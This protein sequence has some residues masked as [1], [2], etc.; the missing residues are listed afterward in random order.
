MIINDKDL[1]IVFANDSCK[2]MLLRNN[3]IG[4]RNGKLSFEQ[5]SMRNAVCRKL[6]SVLESGQGQSAITLLVPG[7]AHVITVIIRPMPEPWNQLDAIPLH[8]LQRSGR[9]VLVEFSNSNYY[10]DQGCLKSLSEAF[11]L[12]RAEAH[13]LG[14][15]ARGLS[16]AEIAEASGVAVSTVRQRIKLILAKT[17]CDRQQ[18]LICLVRSLCPNCVQQSGFPPFNSLPQ[19]KEPLPENLDA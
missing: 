14:E 16:A 1:S 7:A 18:T 15:I 12:T 3:P 11:G 9:L 19:Q 6:S 4:E 5:S 10:P 8:S 13:D 2:Q 17:G